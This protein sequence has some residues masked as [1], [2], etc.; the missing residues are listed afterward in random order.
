MGEEARCKYMRLFCGKTKADLLQEAVEKYQQSKRE[1][2]EVV[3]QMESLVSFFQG[4]FRTALI[5]PSV[6]SSPD[7]NSPHKS[8]SLLPS[9]SWYVDRSLDFLNLWVLAPT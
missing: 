2:D 1:L 4:I 5:H 7:N 3:A 6:K 9:P 8:S